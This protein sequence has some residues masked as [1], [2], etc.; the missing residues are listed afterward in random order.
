MNGLLFEKKLP[1]DGQVG[2]NLG[3]MDAVLSSPDPAPLRSGF[4]ATRFIIRGRG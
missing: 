1:E 2:V 3:F 4:F